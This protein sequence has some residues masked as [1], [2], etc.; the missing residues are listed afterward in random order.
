MQT[1]KD[2]L[3][4]SAALRAIDYDSPTPI[5][6]AVDTSWKAIGFYIYQQDPEDVKK[7]YY[8][9]FE[10]ITLNEREARFSQLKRELFGLMRALEEMI[11]WWIGC[12]KLIAKTDTL[13]IFGML[14]YALNATINHWIEKVLMF[15]FTLRHKKGK[16]FG[17][18]KRS[19]S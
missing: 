19:I 16:I 7:R 13:Y 5:V 10:L 4:A 9:R 18:E 15:H 11:Y 12:R 14:N 8:M 3:V 17:P 2:A 6:L 1:F